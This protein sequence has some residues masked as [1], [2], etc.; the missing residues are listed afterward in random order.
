MA[1]FEPGTSASD[2]QQ[3][4]ALD[5]SATGIGR[6]IRMSWAF[7]AYSRCWALTMLSVKMWHRVIGTSVFDYQTIRRHILTE[8]NLQNPVFTSLSSPV[9]RNSPTIFRSSEDCRRVEDWGTGTFTGFCT[10]SQGAKRPEHGVNHPLFLSLHGRF[11]GRN[12]PLPF[13]CG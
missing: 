1:G 4:L 10:C 5:R 9:R 11:W 13:T 7:C 3:T 6:L 2:Q 8:S 12:L